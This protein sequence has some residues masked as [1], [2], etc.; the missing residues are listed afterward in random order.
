MGLKDD[1]A[2]LRPRAGHDLVLTTDALA[3]EIHFFPYDPPES[4]ARKSLGVNLSDLAAKGADPVG[5]LMTLALPAD[6]T[7]GWLEAFASG[8]GQASRSS[9]CPLLGGD[10]VRA[11]RG[12]TISITAI[13]E[14]PEGRM[15]RRTTAQPGDRI[16]VTGTIGDAALGLALRRNPEWSAALTAEARRFLDDRYLHPQP[17]NAISAI[18]RDHAHSAM[19]V[20][21]GLAG[22]LA[23]LVGAAGLG[24]TVD[25]DL[26]PLSLEAKAAAASNPDLLDVIL[27]G[28]DDYEVLCTVGEEN[29]A[30]FL[31]SAKYVGVPVSVIGT[32]THEPGTPV[33]RWAGAERRYRSGSFSHF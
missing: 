7:E 33:F 29:L 16:C 24:A 9:K 21:D 26:V 23:K 2:L 25:A 20:S 5:F 14:V 1:A 19:Y 13:G 32:V 30:P 10:T 12:L 22:D 3:A 17:R 28:G 31:Q 4:I 11:S 6:W 18:L 8:L 15:V 27:T